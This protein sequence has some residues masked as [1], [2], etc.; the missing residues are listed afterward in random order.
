DRHVGLAGKAIF[1]GERAFAM[2]QR[3]PLHGAILIEAGDIKR[4]GIE[5]IDVRGT[6]IGIE[7]A[8]GDELVDIVEALVIAHVEDNAA[9]PGNDR[10]RTFMFGAAER[11]AL[12]GRGVRIH[13][14]DLNDPAEAV[15][16][17]WLLRE[18]VAVVE[19]GPIVGT[20]RHAVTL[21]VPGFGV[22][23]RQLAIKVTVE[24]FFGHDVGAPGRH[25][26][27]AVVD[28]SDDAGAR[29]IIVGLDAVMAC[30]GTGQLHRRRGRDAAV[31]LAFRYD[32]PLAIGLADL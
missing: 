23:F 8:F 9:I 25:T 32:L 14:V 22:A 27:G 30:D 31:V 19:F 7:G 13:N 18:I 2:N 1:L 3:Q 20:V 21:I 28:R 6:V 10:F 4:A 16:L 15:R 12:L 17:V 5:E 11:C 29:R 24:I 26:A